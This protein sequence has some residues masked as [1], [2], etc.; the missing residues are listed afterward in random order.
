MRQPPHPQLVMRTYEAM[1]QVSLADDLDA[2]TKLFV[3]LVLADRAH[4]KGPRPAAERLAE[5]VGW[6]TRID[7]RAGQEGFCER[8]IRRDVPRYITEPGTGVCVGEAVRGDGPCGKKILNKVIDTDP[9]TGRAVITGYCT[10]HWSLDLEQRAQQRRRQWHENG[11]PYPPANSGDLLRHY[12]DTDWTPYYDLVAPNRHRY[13]MPTQ[14]T[15]RHRPPLA[16]VHG[17]AEPSPPEHTSPAVVRP[18][19]ACSGD[20]A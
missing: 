19:Y 16:L 6:M 12:L 8:V 10:R 11:R 20:D 7:Q 9:H 13:D 2:D 4:R 3:L 15:T 18:L 14:T 17:D 1:Q 5:N